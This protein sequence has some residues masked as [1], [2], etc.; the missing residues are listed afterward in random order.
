MPLAS[1]ASFA[2]FYVFVIPPYDDVQRMHYFLCKNVKTRRKKYHHYTKKIS[3]LS[4]YPKVN[5]ESITNLFCKA[6]FVIRTVF[7]N[8]FSGL[9]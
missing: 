3:P 1:F 7:N 2:I 5:F 4:T 9:N 8:R 6:H